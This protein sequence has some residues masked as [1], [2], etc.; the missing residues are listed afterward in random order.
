[1]KR[2]TKMLIEL[3][4]V[5]LPVVR[6]KLGEVEGVSYSELQPGTLIKDP[7]RNKVYIV[8]YVSKFGDF[9]HVVEYKGGMQQHTKQEMIDAGV[10]TA[11]N[12]SGPWRPLSD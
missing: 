8:V 3:S 2:T 4:G 10:L 1:M 6:K 5:A 9:I 7:K 12:P 11:H